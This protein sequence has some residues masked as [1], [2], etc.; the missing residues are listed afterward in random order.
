MVCGQALLLAS[1]AFISFAQILVGLLV[2]FLTSI[3]E[4]SLPLCTFSRIP[5]EIYHGCLS[6]M[7]DNSSV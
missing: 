7:G 5:P 3:S 6:L 1:P 4:S 2:V